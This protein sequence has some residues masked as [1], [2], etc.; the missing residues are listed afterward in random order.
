L[1]EKEMF[2]AEEMLIAGRRNYKVICDTQEGEI[3]EIGPKVTTFIFFN[4]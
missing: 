2:G 1:G 4:T 3:Y